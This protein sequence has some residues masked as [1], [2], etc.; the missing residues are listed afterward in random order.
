[1]NPIR[2][3]ATDIDQWADRREAQSTL[4]RLIRRLILAS[5]RRVERLHFRSD[6]GVQL[7]GWDGIAQVPEGSFYVPDGVSGWELSTRSDSKV[8]ADDDY[9]TRSDNPLQLHPPNTSF[10]Y[11]TARRW[12]GKENWADEK[13]CEG[14][15]KDV[16]AYDADDLDTWLE[17]APAVDLWFSILLGKRPLGAIDLNSFWD[18]WSGATRP[19]LNPELVMAGR[20]DSVQKIHQWIRSEPSVLGLQADNQDEAIAYFIASLFRLPEEEREHIF[21]RAIVVKDANTWQQ[22][23]LCDTS[24]ILIPNFTDRSMVTTAVEKGHRM[25]FPL[26][27]SEPLIGNT[28]LLARLRRD[29]AEKAL[30]GMGIQVARA[31]DLAALARRSFGALRR[32]LP[33]FPTLLHQSGPSSLK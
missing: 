14:V 20:E 33:F 13:Q 6:E 18:A 30:V 24:L 28:L 5:T 10:V 1:M 25:F 16:R 12:S 2:A 8:K 32:K 27:R 22:L 3:N 21:A 7:A 15:W 31:R 26:D 11:A 17:Q 4:P 23:A 29:E 9:K 19:Q